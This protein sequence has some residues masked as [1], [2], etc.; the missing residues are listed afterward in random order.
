MAIVGQFFTINIKI[1]DQHAFKFDD[2]KL[3]NRVINFSVSPQRM[4]IWYR[5]SIGQRVSFGILINDFS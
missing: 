5:Y 4:Q 3:S 2:S 1:L